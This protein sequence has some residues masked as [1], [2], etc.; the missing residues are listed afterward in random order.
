MASKALRGLT[1][2]IGAE[3]SD[4]N[5][6]LD[7][8][9]KRARSL[10]SELGQVD[11]ALK[12]DPTNTELLAQKQEVLAEAISNTEEKLD[13]LKAAE[14]QVQA[15]FERGEVSQEQVRAL[16]REIIET[17]MKLKAYKKA[18]EDAAD[19]TDEL[20]DSADD[21][22]DDIDEVGEKSE[23]AEKE[24]SSFSD[25]LK[26]GL[27]ISLAGLATAA[28]GAVAGIKS[29]VEETAEYRQGMAKLD[30]AF[31]KSGH[32]TEEAYETYAELQSILGETDQA[33][34]AAN[35]IAKL[36]DNE[37]DLA[38]WTEVCTGVYGE[39]GSSLPVEGL[40]EAANETAKVGWLQLGRL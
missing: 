8:V 31:E 9:D 28:V 6:A 4:L 24:T 37:K 26:K 25:A 30:T 18:A 20:G 5:K 16:R 2:E 14:K 7:N 29:V 15:Q 27:L 35:F 36:A 11:K 23:E 10:S 33:I 38:K 3:T 40:A 13:T 1:I 12:L 17:E 34:E 39:F 22:D 19:A 32:T 21:T